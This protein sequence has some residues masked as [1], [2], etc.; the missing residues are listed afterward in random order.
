MELIS[1]NGEMVL[2]LR[3]SILSEIAEMK[4]SRTAIDLRSHSQRCFH[5]SSPTV[6]LV[7]TAAVVVLVLV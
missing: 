1:A 4:Q 7:S 5:L 2:L 6:D 3:N